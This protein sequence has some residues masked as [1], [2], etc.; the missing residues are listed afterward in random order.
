M[1]I[2][3]VRLNEII[4]VKALKLQSTKL[5]VLVIY[6]PNAFYSGHRGFYNLKDKKLFSSKCLSYFQ[7]MGNYMN[8]R[9]YNHRSEVIRW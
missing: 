8:P 4:I 6:I 1:R 5:Q 7:K 2:R 9:V 3:T